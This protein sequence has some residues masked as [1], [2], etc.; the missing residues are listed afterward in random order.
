LGF[1]TGI[2]Q[3][4]ARLRKLEQLEEIVFTKHRAVILPAV[5]NPFEQLFTLRHGRHA[6]E[7]HVLTAVAPELLDATVGY[8]S[9]IAVVPAV[10]KLLVSVRRSAQPGAS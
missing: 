3:A 4:E 6:G 8:L 1:E 2:D 10:L 5:W 7:Q 9:A